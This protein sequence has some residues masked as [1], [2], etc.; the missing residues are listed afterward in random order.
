MKCNS[1]R[2]ICRHM[3]DCGAGIDAASK[4]EVLTAHA[5][6]VPGKNPVFSPRK[7]R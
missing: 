6:G 1:N 3:A 4:N 5:L 7:K 2:E